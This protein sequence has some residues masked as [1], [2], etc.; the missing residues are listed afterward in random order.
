MTAAALNAK[1]FK[2]ETGTELKPYSS[3]P[4]SYRPYQ[5]TPG[6]R[7]FSGECGSTLIWH[8]TS[9]DEVNIMVG[10]IKDIPAAGLKITE[11]VYISGLRIY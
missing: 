8:D 2:W 7:G 11:V 1:V 6:N 9:G 4:L 5:A 10:T 3:S